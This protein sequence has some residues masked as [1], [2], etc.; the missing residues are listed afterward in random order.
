[1][2]TSVDQR[3]QGVATM[4]NLIS[5]HRAGP[6]GF[7]RPPLPSNNSRRMHA[8]GKFLPW[9]PTLRPTT[10]IH[11]IMIFKHGLQVYLIMYDCKNV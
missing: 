5:A 2:K 7:P 9:H 11:L 4:G 6:L 3:S 1:M 8:R 10:R